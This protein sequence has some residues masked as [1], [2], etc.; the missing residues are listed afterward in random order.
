MQTSG[1]RVRA[2]Y[3]VTKNSPRDAEGGGSTGLRGIAAN[4]VVP[5]INCIAVAKRPPLHFSDGVAHA[6]DQVP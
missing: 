6:H 5:L 2:H 4:R 3:A 1:N